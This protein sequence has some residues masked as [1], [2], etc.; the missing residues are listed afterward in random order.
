MYLTW[1]SESTC[2]A[3]LGPVTSPRRTVGE[4][5]EGV[6]DLLLLD[7]AAAVEEVGRLAAVQLDDVHRGHRQ[8]GPVYWRWTQTARY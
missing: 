8:A 2:G 5:L 7:A 1:K 6:L 4:Q 3:P